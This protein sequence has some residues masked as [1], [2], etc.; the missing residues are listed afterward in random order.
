MS[1]IAIYGRERHLSTVQD[2]LYDCIRSSMADAWGVREE[3]QFQRFIKL[4]DD[5]FRFSGAYSD[6]FTYVEIIMF[7]GRDTELKKSFIRLLYRRVT[8]RC[9]IPANDLEI[10]VHETQRASCGVRG[11]PADEVVFEHDKLTR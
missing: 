3:N 5:D 4:G 7:E 8:E 6:R 10:M 1:H 9:G 11:L 2:E